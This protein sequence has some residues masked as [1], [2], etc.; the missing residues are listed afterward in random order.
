M[1]HMIYWEVFFG[2]VTKF[3]NKCLPKRA[4][5]KY[6]RLKGYKVLFD[7]LKYVPSRLNIEEVY[8]IFKT[9]KADAS[10]INLRIYFE[11]LKSCFLT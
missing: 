2:V 1:Y 3:W 6:F 11:Y 8:Y 10:K 7:F 9:R 4:K 5:R